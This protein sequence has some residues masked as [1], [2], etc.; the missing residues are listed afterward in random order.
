MSIR[1]A[2]ARRAASRAAASS[3]TAAAK[4]SPR[5]VSGDPPRQ[6]RDLRVDI[7]AGVVPLYR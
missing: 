6:R 4:G 1:S 7:D 2:T 3:G 5:P